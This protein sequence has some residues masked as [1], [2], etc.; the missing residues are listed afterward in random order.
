MISRTFARFLSVGIGNT[1]IGLGVIFYLRQSCSD[2]IAN[3]IGYLLVTPI[4]FMTHRNFSFRDTG[5]RIATFIRYLPTMLLGYAANWSVLSLALS[6]GVNG[7]FAQ[8]A[9]IACN[10]V[11]TYTLCR[12][13]VFFPPARGHHGNSSNTDH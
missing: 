3:L 6:I 4:S 9:A 12:I 11:F 5:K 8:T 7:Y 1:L 2:V 13:F 10:V